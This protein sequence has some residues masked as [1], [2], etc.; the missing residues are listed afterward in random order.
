MERKI[1]PS[2][3]TREQFETIRPFLEEVK[4]KTKPR[5]HDLYDIFCAILYILKSCF[6][7]NMLSSDYPSYKTVH[8]YFQIWGK[9]KNKKTSSVLEAVL[10]KMV[11]EERMKNDRNSSASMGIVDAQSV[12]NVHTAREK[13]YD[14]GKEVSSIKRHIIVDTNGLPNA[15]A[16]TTANVT[17]RKGAIE[18]IETNKKYFKRV[19]KILVDGGYSRENFASEVKKILKAETEIAKRN[20]LKKFTVIPKRWVV[21]RSFSWLE[22]RRR[23]WKNCERALNASL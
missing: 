8:Y 22:K 23:L 15:L 1:C 2:D 14:A 20:E 13:V 6:Q 10:K 7:W 17:D 19:K 21:E 11:E 3:I 12:K 16:V 4:K 5:K 18:A 9:K